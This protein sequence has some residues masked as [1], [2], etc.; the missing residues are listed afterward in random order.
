MPTKEIRF[1]ASEEKGHF[2]SLRDLQL[3]VLLK[4]EKG[5]CWAF[6]GFEWLEFTQG[7]GLEFRQGPRIRVR[8]L[9]S[10]G[11]HVSRPPKRASCGFLEALESW[12][13]SQLS[14][15]ENSFSGRNEPPVGHGG[16]KIVTPSPAMMLQVPE[17]WIIWSPGQK[18]P[19]HPKM[20][21]SLTVCCLYVP[22]E[23]NSLCSW[24]W[25]SIHGIPRS[26]PTKCR[27]R[28]RP[29][30]HLMACPS[31][32]TGSDHFQATYKWPSQEMALWSWDLHLCRTTVAKKGK[33]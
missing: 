8:T 30:H 24:L 19:H 17:C 29:G 9:P 22:Q 1:C 32:P 33:S 26:Q 21:L 13:M 7:K 27:A 16:Q 23:G 4:A 5:F 3:L 25:Q 2:L 20:S 6:W 15:S 18:P 14:D 10:W 28:M 12:S 11:L 31:L